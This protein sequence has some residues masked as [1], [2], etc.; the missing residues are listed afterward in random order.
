M[1]SR[2]PC[3]FKHARRGPSTRGPG[4]GLPTSPARQTMPRPFDLDQNGTR[5]I[6]K[7][8]SNAGRRFGAESYWP[9]RRSRRGGKPMTDIDIKPN[10]IQNKLLW[11]AVIA[12]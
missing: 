8:C 5:T 1:E 11:A 9:A 2:F 7:Q 10:G 3:R 4:R 6:D 12:L